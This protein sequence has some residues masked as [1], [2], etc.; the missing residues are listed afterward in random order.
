MRTRTLAPLA[1]FLGILPESGERSLAVASDRVW[2]PPLEVQHDIPS[3]VRLHIGDSLVIHLALRNVS[4]AP[5]TIDYGS[6]LF[7]IVA[8]PERSTPTGN[9]PVLPLP[10]HQSWG[11]VLKMEFP[12]PGAA[13]EAIGYRQT[14]LPGERF[15]PALANGRDAYHVP[16]D[17]TGTYIL[18]L[19]AEVSRVRLC[20]RGPQAFVDVYK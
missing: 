11:S 5:V 1:L 14:I 17:S 9:T 6:R 16:F 12:N 7:I 18:D 2:R 15:V 19:C 8:Q 3:H 13:Y 4:D 10:P 20:N